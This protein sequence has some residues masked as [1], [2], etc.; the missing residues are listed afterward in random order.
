MSLLQHFAFLRMLCVVGILTSA[1]IGGA[2]QMQKPKTLDKRRNQ[3]PLSNSA[4]IDSKL[5]SLDCIRQDERIRVR[6]ANAEFY[7]LTKKVQGL[8]AQRIV[9]FLQEAH[10]LCKKVHE[11][12]ASVGEQQ[13]FLVRLYGVANDLYDSMYRTLMWDEELPQRSDEVEN[14]HNRILA[15]L[16]SVRD[17]LSE[18]EKIYLEIAR[19][20]ICHLVLSANK[21][22]LEQSAE[23]WNTFGVNLLDDRPRKTQKRE[24]IACLEV[25]SRLEQEYGVDGLYLRFAMFSRRELGNLRDDFK[26]LFLQSG[27]ST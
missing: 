1:G 26:L 21:F 19:N 10:T 14:C 4:S 5:G 27:I 2:F 13:L 22:K 11:K 24:I 9:Y 16:K 25:Y 8:Y 3:L 18:P 12:T 7:Q 17:A 20:E 15:N 23:N 6:R